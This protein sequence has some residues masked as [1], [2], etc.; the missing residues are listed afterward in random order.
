[1]DRMVGF[2]G[3]GIMG[4]P[5]AK[6]LVKGGCSL[7]VNDLNGEA[8]KE[9]T[10]MG[11]QAATLKEIGERCPVIFT[12]LPNG[13]IVQSVLFGADGVA[14]GI[15]EGSIVVDMS[16]VTPTESK[17][18][19]EKLAP[20]GVDFLDAPVSGGEPKA[21]DGTLAF[22]VGGKQ[23]AFDKMTPYFDIM[24]ASALLVGETGSGSVTKLANQVI[25]NLNIA[26][27]SE[28]LVLATKAGADPEL[29][30]KAIRGGLAGS[31][32]LDAKAPLMID[33]NFVPGGKISINLK[34][35]KNVMA[36][37]HDIDV[38]LPMSS[39]LL[40]IMQALKVD[41]HLEDDHGG[42]VQYFEKLAGVEVKRKEK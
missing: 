39:Q 2:I 36:T 17:V 41:G 11:A 9:L 29:V 26:A 33:R 13:G 16:S 38:P 21:I 19:A 4:K 40:E 32:V 25:V 18:C 1:M 7:L 24:G 23:E 42:I 35:I 14:E 12:I 10:D 5:M 3:L 28:A 6:N 37:A 8:V 15:R 31:T 27:V 22:M 34:D 30:Y 20:L